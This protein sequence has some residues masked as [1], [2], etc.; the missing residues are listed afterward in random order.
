M[1][2]Q[3]TW[4][5]HISTRR[6]FYFGIRKCDENANLRLRMNLDFCIKGPLLVA[7][8]ELALL[9]A[10]TCRGSF[11]PGDKR[12]KARD[13]PANW[14]AGTLLTTRVCDN[15]F[16]GIWL[17]ETEIRLW[18]QFKASCISIDWGGIMASSE[19]PSNA[20]QG[21]GLQH[22]GQISQ[23]IKPT[24]SSYGI[25]MK[26]RILWRKERVVSLERQAINGSISFSSLRW[27]SLAAQ[28][29]ECELNIE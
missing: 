12:W 23:C 11:L 4:C 10:K 24:I 26:R 6:F 27:E 7:Q 8:W 15:W 1:Y 29:L 21:F 3:W 28:H 2:A 17:L 20:P 18:W 22:R 25:S 13:C 16:F 14:I 9:L 5:G 19:D